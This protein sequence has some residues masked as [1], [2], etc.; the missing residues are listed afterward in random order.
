MIEGYFN[1]FEKSSAKTKAS[2]LFFGIKR[3]KTAQPETI[4]LF[5]N[6]GRFLAKIRQNLCF[7]PRIV[8]HPNLISR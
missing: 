1:F 3:T 5:Q 4:E 8:L 2:F 6:I 7:K